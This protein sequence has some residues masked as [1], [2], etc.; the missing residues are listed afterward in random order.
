MAT[1]KLINSVTVGSG[2]AATISFT[3]IPQ[4]Y[5]DLVFFISSR[6]S[7]NNY[8]GFYMKFNAAAVN[9]DV[10]AKRL[11]GDGST[12]YSSNSKEITW[13]YSSAT[14]NTFGS[15][16]IYIPNYTSSNYK[17]AS[18]EAVQEDNSSGAVSML[19]SWMWSQTAAITQ[20]DFG[21]FDGS[22][23]DNFVQYTTAYL[24]GI[25]NA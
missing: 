5:T 14:A 16:Q 21:T 1:Y 23:P 11:F 3:S 12:A 20:V 18:I 17:S 4:T 24:Y 15:G 25:S 2:G 9:T 7:H 22:F 8:G 19:T 10:T 13:V 6:Q